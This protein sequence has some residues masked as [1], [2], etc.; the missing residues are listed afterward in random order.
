MKLKAWRLGWAMA[1][2]WAGGVF[3]VGVGNLINSAYGIDFLRLIDTIYPGY[4]YGSWG[5]FGVIVASLYA[6]LDGLI[7]GV[8]LAWLYNMFAKEK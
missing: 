6:A 8:V 3:I 7:C 4:H 1:V 5:I 2:L